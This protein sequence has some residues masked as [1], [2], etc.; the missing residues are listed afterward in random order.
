L[1]DVAAAFSPSAIATSFLKLLGDVLMDF[2]PASGSSSTR[3]KNKKRFSFFEF[4]VSVA[5]SNPT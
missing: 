3:N 2:V 4:Q 5:Q 1:P